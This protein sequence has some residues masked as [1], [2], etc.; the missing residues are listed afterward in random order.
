VSSASPRLEVVRFSC[1]QRTS[2]RNSEVVPRGQVGDYF[3]LATI[4]E[5]EALSQD[6]QGGLS[7]ENCLFGKLTYADAWAAIMPEE[8][9]ESLGGVRSQRRRCLPSVDE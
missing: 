5:L 9:T 8:E 3:R 4:R 1:R 7:V 6:V 2:K